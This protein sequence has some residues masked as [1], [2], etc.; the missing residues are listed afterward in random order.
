VEK[1]R[2]VLGLEATAAEVVVVT[3]ADLSD[4]VSIVPRRVAMVREER[5]DIACASRHEKGGRQI[6]GPRLKDGMSRAAGL[7]LR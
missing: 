5:Y 6:G 2:R 7:S 4:D 1:A 3:M